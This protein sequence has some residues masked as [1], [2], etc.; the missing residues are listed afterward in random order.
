MSAA[1]RRVL[2]EMLDE[3]PPED[4]RARRSRRDLQRVHLA[5]ATLSTL[6]R[7]LARLQLAAP[8]RRILELGAGD[9]TLLLRLARAM[10]PSWHDLELTLLDRHD[11]VAPGTHEAYAQFGWRVSVL[12]ADVLDWVREVASPQPDLPHYDLCLTTLFLHHFDD[13]HLA[14]LLAAVAASSD[15][16]VACEPRRDALAQ[17][18]SHLVG[19]IGGNKV[20]REDAVTSV[21]AGFRHQELSA[22]WPSAHGPWRISEY[23]ARPFTHCFV[24]AHAR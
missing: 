5:M 4:P 7:A 11:I 18:G 2:P 1:P 21:A 9:G 14:G 12:R 16:F 6:R 19:V 23:A 15:A 13:V 3:L 17:L 24:A 22:L 20:T 10:Q 8:P